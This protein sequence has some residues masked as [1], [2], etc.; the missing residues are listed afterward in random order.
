MASIDL[1]RGGSNVQLPVEVSSEI[2]ANT[3]EASAVM[4]LARRINLPGPGVKVQTITGDATAGWVDETAEKPVS[5]ATLGTKTIT[6]YKLAVIEPFSNEFRRDLPAL[7]AELARRLPFALAT[8]FDS[9]VFT[10]SAPGSGFDVLSGAAAIAIK[11]GSGATKSTYIGLVNADNAVS[12]V[13]GSVTGWALAPQARQHLLGAV[14]TSG[15][16]LFLD[17]AS[18]GGRG[19]QLLGAPTQTV[20]AAYKAGSPNQV[21]VAGDWS[22]AMF[23]TVA[24]VQISISDTATIAD[25][26][27]TIDTGAV[28]GSTNPI[29]VDVPNQLNLWQRNMFA[30]RAEIEVGFVVRSTDYFVRLTDTAVS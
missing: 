2:W 3:V 23:G 1:N 27:V 15:R 6:P 29:T 14:D 18:S 21:G 28:D 30:I 12:A 11:A 16:P 20:K 7:Y 24:G 17:S 19:L 5:R 10:G 4:S 8:K 22:E 9:T 26:T 13:G 25:G